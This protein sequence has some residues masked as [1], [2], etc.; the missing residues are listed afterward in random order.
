MIF[1][2][3]IGPVNQL[4]TFVVEIPLSTI[5]VKD[6]RSKYA[7]AGRIEQSVA[8]TRTPDYI[9]STKL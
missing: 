9:F 7:V 2:F 8:T 1:T 3:K 4:H 5:S 6:M